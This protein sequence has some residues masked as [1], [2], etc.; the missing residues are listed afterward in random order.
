MEEVKESMKSGVSIAA[1][2]AVAA[3]ARLAAAREC[4]EI[5]EKAAVNYKNHIVRGKHNEAANEEQSSMARACRAIA[6]E[7]REKFELEKGGENA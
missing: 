5:A 4:A 1:L 7:I 6:R 3:E 2:M